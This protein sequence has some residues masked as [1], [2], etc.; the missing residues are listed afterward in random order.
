MNCLDLTIFVRSG[1]ISKAPQINFVSGKNRTKIG[2]VKKWRGTVTQTCILT[3]HGRSQYIKQRY[4]G[5]VADVFESTPR[6]FFG[7]R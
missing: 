4:A 7:W 6:E 2:Q 5:A 1:Q 3:C